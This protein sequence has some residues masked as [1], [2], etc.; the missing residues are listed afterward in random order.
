MHYEFAETGNKEI[1]DIK[2]IATYLNISISEVRKLVRE[3]RIPFFRIGNRLKFDLRKIDLWL[4]EKQE[5]E[6]N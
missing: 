4:D 6:S 1:C 3:K 2:K 5:M